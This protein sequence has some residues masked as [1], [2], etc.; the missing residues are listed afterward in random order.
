MYFSISYCGLN[1]DTN[2]YV[3]KYL[4]DFDWDYDYLQGY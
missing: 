3:R 1:K 2:K 4:G